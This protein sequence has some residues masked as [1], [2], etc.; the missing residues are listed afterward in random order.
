MFLFLWGLFIFCY[1]YIYQDIINHFKCTVWLALIIVCGHKTTTK[2]NMQNSLLTL[3]KLSC[4]NLFLLL[5]PHL[6]PLA[7]TYLLLSLVLLFFSKILYTWKRT[8]ICVQFLS[9][10]C[11][12]DFIHVVACINT[13]FLLIVGIAQIYRTQN[14]QFVYPFPIGGHLSCFHLGLSGIILSNSFILDFFYSPNTLAQALIF[15]IMVCH[16]YY[17]E[18]FSKTADEGEVLTPDLPICDFGSDL[19]LEKQQ[20]QGPKLIWRPV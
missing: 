3:K 1:I 14:I 8:V 20:C 9:L 5:S 10:A 18:T 7:T 15:M 2:V 19:L 17:S 16:H 13:S 12:W 4:L 11:F 6:W